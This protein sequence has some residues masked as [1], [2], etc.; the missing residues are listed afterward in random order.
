MGTTIKP[1]EIKPEIKKTINLN[2][3]NKRGETALQC[4]CIKLDYLKAESLIN[5]GAD[6][7]TRDNNGWTPLHEVAQRNHLDLVRLL[8]EAGA[9]PN[10]PGG[11][12]NYTP[13][14]DAVEAGHV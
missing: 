6:P 10:V 4:A 2:K 9:N 12:E 5:E 7:N 8:L 11:D 14:H 1:N 13:L 3:K